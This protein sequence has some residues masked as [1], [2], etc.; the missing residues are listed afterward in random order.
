[1]AAAFLSQAIGG[2]IGIVVKMQRI[3]QS[4]TAM[5]IESRPEVPEPDAVGRR[6]LDSYDQLPAGERRL[7][8]VLLARVRELPVFRAHELAAMA[9][10][11]NATAA[12]LFKRLGFASF[13]EA[14][15]VARAAATA[16]PPG[17]P[18]AE[19]N[20][21]GRGQRLGHGLAAHLEQDLTNLVR[22]LEGLSSATLGHAIRLLARARRLRVVGFRNSHALA[23]YAAGVLGTI[24]PEVRLVAGT[25][26]N[27]AEEMAGLAQGDAL[28]VL[29]FRRRP[30]ILEQI[31]G[32]AREIG[33]DT[34]LIAERDAGRIMTLASVALP[35]EV[36]G[37]SLFDSYVAAMSLLNFICSEMSVRFGSEAYARL[38]RIEALHRRF[39]DLDPAAR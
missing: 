18:L 31:I 17:S 34:V 7:A 3:F 4:A 26:L 20:D 36:R 14:R 23:A 38:A 37:A 21:P 22:S 16:E 29:G 8:D 19:L 5:S 33:A 12:R 35:C 10:V 32:E 2:R 28:L 13:D 1:M 25:G 39:E 30:R 15:R 27:L 24:R 11:S 9:G 6:I